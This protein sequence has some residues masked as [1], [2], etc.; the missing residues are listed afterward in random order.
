ML[1]RSPTYVVS[2]PD[3]RRASPT[4]SRK[5]LPER[6]AYAITRWK[7]VA[8]PAVHLPPDAHPAG[9]GEGRSCSTWCARSSGPT[10]TSRRTSRRATTR[11]T[12][13][14]AWCRTAICSRRSA[15]A[16][17]RSS[18]T[19]SSTFTETG[20]A[21]ASGEEL[22]AD[23]IVTATGLQW[24]MLGEMDFAVDGEPVDFAKTWTYKGMM[25]SDVP[26]LVSHVRLHQRLVDAAR[27][28][29]L[30]S[31]S[32]GCSTTWTRRGTRQVHA[33]AARRST[34][35]CR[36][37]RGSTSFSSGYMQRD[38]A[39]VP[40]AGRPRAVDQPA[41]LRARQED[42]PL[43]P[44]S[45]TARSSSSVA[46]PPTPTSRRLPPRCTPRS[47]PRDARAGARPARNQHLRALASRGTPRT[48]KEKLGQRW[49]VVCHA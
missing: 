13:A 37:G 40:Q 12:S 45:R 30:P 47:K 32:A 25:Y 7:N 22:E 19:R 48:V 38:D 3:T 27:R 35:T 2:R 17:R 9:E 21:L 16:R 5:V 26:N 11:G 24:S 44:R 33:A 31:T 43:R 1:Q 46:D 14:S 18:P 41:E 23:I 28:P 29:H 6:W 36:R 8:L 10:T 15:P 20:I 39:P 49:L 4:R 34:A 42:D